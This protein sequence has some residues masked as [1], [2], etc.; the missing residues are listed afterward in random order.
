MAIYKL[1]HGMKL[2]EGIMFYCDLH[3]CVCVCVCVL[4]CSP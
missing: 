1:K 3:K 2:S 4:Y